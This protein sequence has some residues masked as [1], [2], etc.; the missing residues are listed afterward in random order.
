[1]KILFLAVII[2]FWLPGA[3]QAANAIPEEPEPSLRDQIRAARA[4]E[5][6]AEKEAS[7]KRPWDRNANGQRPWELNE[8]P[9]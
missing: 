4:K 7:A 8:H 6:I 3:S 9:K 5:D 1:M 2:A